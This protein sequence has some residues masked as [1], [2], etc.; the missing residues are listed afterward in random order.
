MENTRKRG[1][2]RESGDCREGRLSWNGCHKRSW[3]DNESTKWK[4][5][6]GEV[7][8]RRVGTKG[9]ELRRVDFDG[10]V[11]GDRW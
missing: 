2:E 4:I 10:E 9:Q 11:Y 6:V 3:R 1:T 8:R 5:G 7:V